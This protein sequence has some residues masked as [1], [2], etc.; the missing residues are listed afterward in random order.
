[1]HQIARRILKKHGKTDGHAWVE[2]CIDTLQ[3]W[4]GDQAFVTGS[5]PSLGDV[6][7]HGALTCVVDFPIH[8]AIMRRPTVA[9]WNGRMNGLRAAN[10]V[11][12]M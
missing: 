10:R 1:M 11:A 5:T 12:P 8:A 4:L 2:S 7:V 9:A 6:A 3:G